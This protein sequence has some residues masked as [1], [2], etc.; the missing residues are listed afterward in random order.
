[1]APYASK[2]IGIDTS[3]SMLDIYNQKVSDDGLSH[4]MH[5]LCL[6]IMTLDRYPAELQNVDVVVCSMAYHHLDH[7]VSI[8]K[9]LVAMLKKGGHLLV[10][11]ILQSRPPR[12]YF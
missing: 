8:S 11:D 10:V 12:G 5:T 6:D 1:L 7:I 2:I 9:I 3:Q 4:K